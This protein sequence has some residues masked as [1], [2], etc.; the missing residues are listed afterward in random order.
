MRPIKKPAPKKKQPPRKVKLTV[1][2]TRLA[3][4]AMER[5]K[6][7]L[8]RKGHVDK[9]GPAATMRDLA[10]RATYLGVALPPSYSA[11]MRVAGN[12][13]D[14]ES[15]LSA[16][17]MKSAFDEAIGA[18]MSRPDVERYAPFC[19]YAGVHGMSARFACFDREAHAEDGELPVVEW[20]GGAVKQIA[21]HF[22]EWLDEVADTREEQV[23]QAAE[24]PESLRILLEQL[25]FTFDD[26]IVGRLETGDTEAIEELL[27]A[28]RVPEV[29]GEVD[30]LFDSSGKASLTLNLDEF[31][32][33]TALRTGIYVFEPE[34]VFRWL[35][36]F[37]DENFFG[38]KAKEPSHPDHARDLRRAPREP[39][40]IL[41]GVL[42]VMPLPARRHHFR[43]AGGRSIEDFY[44]LGRT[45]STHER[46]PSLL[47]HIVNGEVRG[48]HSLDE[49]LIDVYVTPEGIIWGLSH[50]GT[51]VR[52]AGSFD[53]SEGS[54]SRHRG[55]DVARAFPLHRGT[56]GRAWWNGIGGGGDRVLVWGAGAVLSFDGE[57]FIPFEPDAQ[58]EEHE[59]VAALCASRREIAMLVCGDHVGAVARFDGKRWLT[60]TEE[61]VIEA[62]L[63]DLDVWRGVS[64]VLAR[65]G[66]LW[67]SEGSG[68]PRPV[69]WDDRQ[70]AFLTESGQ[71]RAAYAVRSFDGGALVASDG[72][73]ISV[74]AGE[75]IFH[76]ASLSNEP[77]RLARVG[78]ERTWSGKARESDPGE[79]RAGIVATCGPHAW[80][81]RR[82]A[83]Y[84]IDLREW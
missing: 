21:R 48:A 25:G 12:I 69:I 57:K 27:G 52:L 63:V 73:V 13:G 79:G 51:A 30:R 62:P 28:E 47:L 46:S 20:H 78:G 37:R 61:Q 26:P 29:R 68:R 53:K 38:D 74:G 60:I 40:L 32:L 3:L 59:S 7:V 11:A 83:F 72:G 71:A 66:E 44:L 2:P 14:P 1:D 55:G 50:S 56:R 82:D 43:A 84:V 15:L 23:E 31:T 76:A 18:R 5:I 39:P 17:E 24:I 45:G 8:T 6:T 70:Q 65:T 34:D 81:W 42:D 54:G 75:P 9:F 58:L 49:P 4:A 22:A 64:I 77:A 10:A 67:R 19:R 36:W 35:R 16:A 41:R 33:A 80:I